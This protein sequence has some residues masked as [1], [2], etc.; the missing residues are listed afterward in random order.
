MT[1]AEKAAEEEAAE[2]R[3]AAKGPAPPPTAVLGYAPSPNGATSKPVT[4]KY[5]WVPG[6]FDNR[7]KPAALQMIASSRLMDEPKSTSPRS[8]SAEAASAN[9]SSA[10]LATAETGISEVAEDKDYGDVW[11]D[12]AEHKSEPSS[13]W[14]CWL[15][16]PHSL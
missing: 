11:R 5:S 8:D 3:A 13:G 2:A 4:G 16:V 6:F 14:S 9:Q 1:Q 12:A 10:Q 15:P 7:K